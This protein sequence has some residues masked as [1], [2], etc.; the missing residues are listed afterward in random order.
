MQRIQRFVFCLALLIL[1]SAALSAQTANPDKSA[2]PRGQLFAGYGFF[3]NSFNGHS[4]GQSFSPLNGW[5][6]AFETPITPHLGIKIDVAG[7]YGTS[8]GAPQHPL[9]FLAGPQYNHHF[10]KETGFVD[11][12]V[13]YGHINSSFWGGD[14]P[15]STNTF[16]FAADAGLD[17]PISPRLAFRVQGGYQYAGFNIPD[18]QIHNQPRNFARISTGIVWRF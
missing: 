17:T 2:T 5:N 3:S 10:G 18:N 7:Y 4:T 11:G 16:T 14:T 9:F 15:P 13:G 6:A 8:L 12:L 1:A